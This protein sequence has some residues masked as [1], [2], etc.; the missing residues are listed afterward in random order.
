MAKSPNQ[1]RIEKDIRAARLKKLQGEYDELIQ[2]IAHA[3]S[4]EQKNY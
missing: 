2:N 1:I 3:P 4:S